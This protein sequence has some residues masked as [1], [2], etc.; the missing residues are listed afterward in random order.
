MGRDFIGVWTG[1]HPLFAFLFGGDSCCFCCCYI[2]RLVFDG[3]SRRL[4]LVLTCIENGI[5]GCRF[6]G[7]LVRTRLSGR[8]PYGLFYG[9]SFGLFAGGLGCT[10]SRFAEKVALYWLFSGGGC[11]TAFATFRGYLG[12]LFCCE[13][14]EVVQA[15]YRGRKKG[16]FDFFFRFG[17]WFFY[18]SGYRF[19]RIG[20]GRRFGWGRLRCG[21]IFRFGSFSL[22]RYCFRC[23]CLLHFFGLF[24]CFIQ[25]CGLGMLHLCPALLFFQREELLIWMMG[26]FRKM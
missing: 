9:L 24:R 21:S 25:P 17:Q 4:L 13:L 6:S 1:L 19:Y 16:K 23:R 15:Q 8:L 10:G 12:T 3:C 5:N 22:L 2:S 11:G 26:I 7:G 20:S 18:G 14:E